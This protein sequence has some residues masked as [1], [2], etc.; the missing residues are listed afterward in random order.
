MSHFSSGGPLCVWL[1]ILCVIGSLKEHLHLSWKNIFRQVYENMHLVSSSLLFFADLPQQRMQND[2]SNVR[3]W[4]W[5]ASFISSKLNI[6][7]P[8]NTMIIIVWSSII[9]K[10]DQSAG[11]H[12][13]ECI[14][15]I[16]IYAWDSHAILVTKYFVSSPYLIDSLET[17][18]LVRISYEHHTRR[19]HTN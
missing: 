19:P 18:Q 1:W 7:Y 9:P 16:I 11:I 6:W 3:Y 14:S 17:S 4:V 2:A 8:W 15:I 12:F 5:L 10:G 13:I